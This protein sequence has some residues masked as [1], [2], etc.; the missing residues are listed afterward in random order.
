[1]D[2]E[3]DTYYFMEIIWNHEKYESI[4][5]IYTYPIC[6]ISEIIIFG[7]KWDMLK[8]MSVKR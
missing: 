3:Y 6:I 2:M 8:E 5:L 7:Y 1:M 4:F